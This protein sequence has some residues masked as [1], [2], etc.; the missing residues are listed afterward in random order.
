MP[1][2]GLRTSSAVD[3]VL[4]QWSVCAFWCL[5]F[6]LF[7]VGSGTLCQVPALETS[8]WCGLAQPFEALSVPVLYLSPRITDQSS[9]NS[10]SIHFVRET[11]WPVDG[12]LSPMLF[13]LTLWYRV[14]YTVPASLIKFRLDFVFVA[15]G[16]NR[17]AKLFLSLIWFWSRVLDIRARSLW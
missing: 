11:A 12:A 6:E 10:R 3:W 4:R 8:C 7:Y 1:W 9:D 15:L 5:Q 13:V 16:L 2:T 14:F 17:F